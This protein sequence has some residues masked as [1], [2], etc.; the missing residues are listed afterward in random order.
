MPE[1]T[2]AIIVLLLLAAFAI[3]VLVRTVRIVQQQ[4]ALIIE[5]LGRYSR[6]LEGGLHILRAVVG[7]LGV[8]V[9]LV[10]FQAEM[11]QRR[12][13]DRLFNLPPETRG[14]WPAVQVALDCL[15][16]PGAIA[17]MVLLVLA[18]VVLAWPSRAARQAASEPEALP[19]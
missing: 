19:A 15:R 14:G 2:F 5:R 6:T 7:V 3:L 17:T 11:V 9:A 18:L 1:G 16:M 10:P 8:V 4:T 12:P 13:W